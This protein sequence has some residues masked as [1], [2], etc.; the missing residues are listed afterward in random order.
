MFRFFEQ[1][2]K[3]EPP[4]TYFRDFLNPGNMKADMGL[5]FT[6]LNTAQ[7]LRREGMSAMSY[8]FLDTIRGK[9][10]DMFGESA[11]FALP[12]KGAELRGVRY[13]SRPHTGSSAPVD[14]DGTIKICAYCDYIHLADFFWTRGTH[15]SNYPLGNQVWQ[16]QLRLAR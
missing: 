9:R 15:N 1:E 4:N 12:R 10:P 6:V 2:L 16:A 8:H 11:T 3:I 13:R 5:F 7:C 14:K